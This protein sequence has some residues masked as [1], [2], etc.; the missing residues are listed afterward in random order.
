MMKTAS[1]TPILQSRTTYKHPHKSVL[2]NDPTSSVVLIHRSP[3]SIPHFWKR[4]RLPLGLFLALSLNGAIAP[5]IYAATN[6]TTRGNAYAIGLLG[7]VVTGLAVYLT[8]V[9]LKPERF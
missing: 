1:S 3:T 6:E 5:A 9:I 8:L 4:Y 7:L 2:Q